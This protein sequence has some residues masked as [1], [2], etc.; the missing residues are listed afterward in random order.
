MLRVPWEPRAW[1]PVWERKGNEEVLV[2]GRMG[3]DVLGKGLSMNLVCLGP[4]VPSTFVGCEWG[5]EELERGK[6]DKVR[7]RRSQTEGTSPL[8]PRYIWRHQAET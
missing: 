4:R 8:R 3:K 2:G 1:G 7:C 6:Q 5:T